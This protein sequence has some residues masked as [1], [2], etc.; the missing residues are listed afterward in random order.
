MI[1]RIMIEGVLKSILQII[2]FIFLFVVV[3]FLTDRYN[4]YSIENESGYKLVNDSKNAYPFIVIYFSS[5]MFSFIVF[6]VNILQLF[7]NSKS[8]SKLFIILQLL[9]WFI[10]CLEDY[11][12][13]R[14]TTIIMLLVGVVTIVLP[15]YVYKP[16]ISK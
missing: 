4:H 14:K 16:K 13:R 11:D 7:F 9:L 12:S 8:N 10:L 15:S 5:I 1:E 3:Y 6:S 2:L